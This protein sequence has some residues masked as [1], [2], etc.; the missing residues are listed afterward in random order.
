M[1]ESASGRGTRWQRN[2]F[3]AV[4]IGWIAT[5][6]AFAILMR[7][8]LS[9]V[10]IE[11]Q[12][13][14]AEQDDTVQATASGVLSAALQPIPEP[15]PTFSASGAVYV[16]LYSSL[17][18]GGERVLKNVSTTLSIRNRSANAAIAVTSVTYH[19]AGGSTVAEPLAQPHLLAPMAVAEFY[20]DQRPEA[21]GPAATVVV[22]WGAETPSSP[23]LVE[24]VII[25]SYGG[26]SLS[27]ISRGSAGP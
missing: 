21:G 18:V 11:E 12:W 14:A 24:A 23:P 9:N 1:T 7:V 19:A 25:G 6:A 3:F 5:I 27:F 10:D 4:F 16:P 15:A 13:A 2:V 20:I 26:R 22:G 17:Y 8:V